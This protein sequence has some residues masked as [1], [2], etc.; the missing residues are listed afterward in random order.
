MGA[1]VLVI[2]AGSSGLAAAAMLAEAG[3]Q[4]QV[5]ARGHG[6][7]HWAAGG[8]DVLGRLPAGDE[9]GAGEPVERPLEALGRLPDGHPYSLVGEG[10]LL[11]GIGHVRAL[12]DRAGIELVGDPAVNRSQITGIGTR[13]T[14][15]LLQTQGDGALTGRVAA[16]GFAGFEDFSSHLCADRLHRIGL[17]AVPIEIPLPQGFRGRHVNAVELARAFDGREF[18]GAVAGTLGRAA[19]GVDVCVVPAVIGLA[20]AAEAWADL[21]ELAGLRVVE[22]ALPPPSIPGLR[23]FD[24]WRERLSELGVG[25]RLGLPAIGAERD[26]DRVTA[27]LGEGAS[28]PIRIPCDEVVLATGGVAGGGIETY[29]DGTL[30][31]TVLGLP[32]DGFAHRT[33]FLAADFFGSHRLA[34]AGVR[35]NRELRPVDRAGVPVLGNVRVI[36]TQLAG[37]DPTAEG[38]REGVGLATAARAAELLA[39]ARATG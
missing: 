27:I 5:I 38:S 13:R 15:A 10:A 35:V 8:I 28:G 19:A 21:Q 18:R 20:N 14:T 9:A 32:I 30:A 33:E 3:Q 1:D 37:H 39:G 12:T 24:A 34:Q 31:E 2:G 16:I 36:G 29:R 6:F 4:V 22:A 23:L 26:G 17:D 11:A 7:T 25:W